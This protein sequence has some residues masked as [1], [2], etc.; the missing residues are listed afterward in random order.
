LGPVRKVSVTESAAQPEKTYGDSHV[1][2]LEDEVKLL[3]MELASRESR[4]EPLQYSQVMKKLLTTLHLAKIVTEAV[5]KK[6]DDK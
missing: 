4:A 6:E 3:K 5:Q 2:R 1:K